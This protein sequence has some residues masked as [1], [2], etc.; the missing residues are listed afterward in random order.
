MSLIINTSQFTG[1]LN[2]S[3]SVIFIKIFIYKNIRI[4][5]YH[6]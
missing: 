6:Y 2:K 5:I 1:E 4:L 3:K